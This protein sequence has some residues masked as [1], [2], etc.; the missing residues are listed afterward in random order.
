MFINI[1]I[2]KIHKLYIIADTFSKLLKIYV[3][4]LIADCS[5]RCPSG[6]NLNRD[7]SQC[8]C[9]DDSVSGKVTHRQSSLAL[10]NVNI[11]IVGRE[12]SPSAVSG[13]DGR[14]TISGVCVDGLK[15]TARKDG[16]ESSSREY[17]VSAG[18]SVS[19]VMHTL[20]EYVVSSG[21]NVRVVVYTPSDYVSSADQMFMCSINARNYN[22][23]TTNPT[24]HLH[25]LSAVILRTLYS[26]VERTYRG[27]FHRIYRRSVP[28]Y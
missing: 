12:W 11:Y 19:V 13:S 7:C 28:V 8:L 5:R 1:K 3:L 18:S 10:A 24:S 16:Y 9:A 22:A 6:G 25:A 21:S 20:G 15:L 26:T 14:F 23:E 27:S 2:L 17:S 4:I